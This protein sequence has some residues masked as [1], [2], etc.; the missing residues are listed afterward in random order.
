MDEDE[1]G[2][3]SWG[4]LVPMSYGNTLE[5]VALLDYMDSYVIGLENS[6]I[7][8][9]FASHISPQ[10]SPFFQH[11]DLRYE[12]G[13]G[14]FSVVRMAVDKVSGNRVAVKII[15]KKKHLLTTDMETAYE[16]EVQI[17]QSLR[18]RNIVQFKDAFQTTNHMFLVQE[19]VVG[20][21]LFH[22]TLDHTYLS[23]AESRFF[24]TQILDVLEYL[25]TVGVVH[26]DLKPDNFLIAE[27]KILKLADFG[28]AKGVNASLP[29]TDYQISIAPELMFNKW[30]Q[31]DSK[32]DVYSSGVILFWMLSGS[33]PYDGLKQN[34]LYDK[35]QR[36]D[37]NWTSDAWSF[38]SGH[39]KDLIR[40]L[41]Q[42]NP[43]QRPSAATAHTS[44]WLM[45]EYPCSLAKQATPFDTANGRYWGVL[46][47]A[48]GP[49]PITSCKMFAGVVSLGRSGENTFQLKDLRISAKHCTISLCEDDNVRL[50]DFST[51]GIWVNGRRIKNETLLFDGDSV[52]L[53]PVAN[54]VPMI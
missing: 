11:Y 10:D 4:R 7:V 21:T 26:R 13:H 18:H 54:G 35:I 23:E 6:N 30:G 44:I 14:N 42:P 2:G 3:T 31:Y 37:I 15:D 17:L 40:M 46:Y 24:F 9:P 49:L 16:R 43:L 50:Q 1:G 47:K 36:G 38:V 19:L 33:L 48:S 45:G 29:H 32:V 41:L 8:V 53:A 25:N 12:L 5:T 52:V 51:N 39:A 28:V 27:S 34:D 20:G 22:Y